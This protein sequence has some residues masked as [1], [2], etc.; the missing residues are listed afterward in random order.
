[1]LNR[2][3]SDFNDIVGLFV[4][5]VVLRNKVMPE[6]RLIDFLKKTAENTLNAYQNQEV[7]FD[8]LQHIHNSQNNTNNELVQVLCRCYEIT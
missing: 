1:M 8:T 2:P 3:G 7:T 6:T 4:N 5:T